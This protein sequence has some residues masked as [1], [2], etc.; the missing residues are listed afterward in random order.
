MFEEAAELRLS[1]TPFLR[2]GAATLESDCWDPRG[3]YIVWE[4]MNCLSAL[5]GSECTLRVSTFS[6]FPV[7][8][9]VTTVVQTEMSCNSLL[10]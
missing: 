4:H 3:S 5:K 8:V 1:S 6:G 7:R 10:S 9:K 2:A